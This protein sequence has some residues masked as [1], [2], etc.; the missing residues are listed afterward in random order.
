VLTEGTSE[1]PLTLKDAR[2]KN[3]PEG[4]GVL[5]GVAQVFSN[6]SNMWRTAQ[7]CDGD[8]SCHRGPLMAGNSS[9]KGNKKCKFLSILGQL[10]KSAVEGWSKMCGDYSKRPPRGA[11]GA[12]EKEYSS[13]RKKRTCGRRFGLTHLLILRVDMG[14]GKERGSVEWKESARKVPRK[15]S[16]HPTGKRKGVGQPRKFIL[17]SHAQELP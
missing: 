14:R 6:T 16:H 13:P 9:V 10:H 7:K 5:E 1:R 3:T 4:K 8:K 15:I 12:K 2:G 11:R 17:S